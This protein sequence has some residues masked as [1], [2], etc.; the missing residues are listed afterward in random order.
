MCV[1]GRS[2]MKHKSR[3]HSGGCFKWT[4]CVPS[5]LRARLH[6]PPP[7]K[8]KPVFS[9][10][11]FQNSPSCSF[12][13]D[14]ISTDSSVTQTDDDAPIQAELYAEY[15]TCTTKTLMAVRRDVGF[16]Y[17]P[18]PPVGRTAAS[19]IGLVW[20]PRRGVQGEEL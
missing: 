3:I 6:H 14:Y 16:L 2:I 13:F 15:Q 19:V 11:T 8:V 9:K 12:Y 4:T 7:L 17:P 18:P 1:G 5:T 20:F 10:E